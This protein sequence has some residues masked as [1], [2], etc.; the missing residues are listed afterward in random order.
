V[1]P[2]HTQWIH[3]VDNKIRDPQADDRDEGFM[4]PVAGTSEVLEKGAMVNPESGVVEDYEELWEDLDIQKV[5]NEKS[6]VSW[7]L[8]NK[9]SRREKGMVIRIGE[10]IQGVLRR[11]DEFSVGR[12]KWESGKG[13]Q[14]VLTIGDGL[15]LSETL[16]GE[17]DILVGHTF[18][19]DN[20]LEW[21]CKSVHTWT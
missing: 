20:G 16:F 11:G 19:A 8:R 1:K 14:R 17:Q 13:W 3:E 18:K 6:H 21:E 2:G 4:Y 7:V 15:D 12:W 9:S 10:W 5:G